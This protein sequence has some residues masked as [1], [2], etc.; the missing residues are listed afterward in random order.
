MKKYI[1]IAIFIAIVGLFTDVVRLNIVNKNLSKNLDYTTNNVKAYS[2]ENSK[3][4]DSNRVFE[5]KASQL[6][7]YNDSILE[8][9]DSVRKV[10]KIK[11]KNLKELQYIKTVATKTDTVSFR[12]TLFRDREL[13]VDTLIG[14]HWYNVTLNLRYPNKIIITPKFISEKYIIINTKRETINPPKKW[15]LLRLFQK[16][17]TVMEVNVVEKNPYIITE[18]NKFIEIVK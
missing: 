5:F 11:D 10:L 9:L 6:Q 3:L 2:S 1:W 8:K 7:Y 17:Q 16:K 15:W 14:D 4:K 18:Q 12:D 13:R